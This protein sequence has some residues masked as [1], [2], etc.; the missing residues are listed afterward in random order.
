MIQLCKCYCIRADD[1]MISGCEYYLG[2]ECNEKEE[3]N[4]R[5]GDICD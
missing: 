2:G 4:N 5:G 1:N 3:I